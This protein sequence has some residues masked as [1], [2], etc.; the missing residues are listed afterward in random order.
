MIFSIGIQPGAIKDVQNIRHQVPVQ[1]RPRIDVTAEYLVCV[2]LR[3]DAHLKG[4]AS[5]TDPSFRKVARGPL[6]VFYRIRSLD[7]RYVEVSHFRRIEAR[8]E[9]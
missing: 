2:E 5:P 7:D 9:T 6:E 1:E 4:E 3:E 8:P